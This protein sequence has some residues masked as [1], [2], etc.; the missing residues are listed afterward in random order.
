MTKKVSELEV[1]EN[2][3][4]KRGPKPIEI[5]WDH[6]KKLCRLQCT[7]PEIASFFDCSEDTVENRCKSEHG[8][9]F[10]EL[11]A[12]YSAY[13][14]LSL[15]RW[16][17]KKAAEGN[18]AMMIWLGKQYLGQK[19]VIENTNDLDKLDA[20]IEAMKKAAEH[21]VQPKAS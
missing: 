1:L 19:E 9:K 15:R 10:S 11:F 13:G 16:Q 8:M 18:V 7:L 6:F 17:F 14:R 2:G 21:A 12:Q 5:D 20:L 4:Q 3:P